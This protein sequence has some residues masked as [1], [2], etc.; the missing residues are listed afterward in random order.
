MKKNEEAIQEEENNQKTNLQNSEKIITLKDINPQNTN[1]TEQ[2]QLQQLQQLQQPGLLEL[3]TRG[4][5]DEFSRL[6][7]NEKQPW[8][9]WEEK[10]DQKIQKRIKAK[11]FFE[12]SFT[13]ATLIRS[14]TSEFYEKNTLKVNNKKYKCGKCGKFF[15]ASK[16][17]E[18]H[19][20]I[21]H[22]ID[23]NLIKK[24]SLQ[25]QF[26]LNYINDES[27]L[28]FKDTDNATRSRSK[29]RNNS[30]NRASFNN[31]NSNRNWRKPQLPFDYNR[32]R[33]TNIN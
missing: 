24:E 8:Q 23:I 25:E 2:Q 27:K 19:L 12:E 33:N 5:Q 11:Q 13:A 26:F 6:I 17:V 21:K 29:N 14:K 32:S 31:N 30:Y 3:L 18:K 1:I 9:I 15:I 10:L 16:F 28:T 7:R 22:K 4:G 20:N